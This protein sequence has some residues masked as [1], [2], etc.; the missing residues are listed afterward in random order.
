M[1]TSSAS[2]VTPQEKRTV[3][4]LAVVA[5][6][7]V[8]MLRIPAT[9]PNRNAHEAARPLQTIAAQPRFLVAVLCAAVGYAVMILVMTA[10]PLAMRSAG[11][12]LLNLLAAGAVVLFISAGVALAGD[13]FWHFWV[14]LVLLGI[15]WNFMFVGG[16]TLLTH[17]PAEQT[18]S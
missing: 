13:S 10:T 4:L 3:T 8:T 7:L 1:N 16:S 15:G 18:D 9:A 5:A 11:L 12:G 2:I 17:T 14:A 6:L